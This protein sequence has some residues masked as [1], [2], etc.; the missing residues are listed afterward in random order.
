LQEVLINQLIVYI[1]IQLS[2]YILIQPEALNV[3]HVNSPKC[4]QDTKV[5][6]SRK[7]TDSREV[8]KLKPI[9]K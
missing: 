2:M 1:L 4:N 8:T 7:V 5:T 3:Q 6:N 9:Q